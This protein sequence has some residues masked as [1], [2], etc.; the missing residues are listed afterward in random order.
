[1]LEDSTARPN[2]WLL[3]ISACSPCKFRNSQ[4]V[5]NFLIR[6]S[7]TVNDDKNSGAPA[8]G[9]YT[10][11]FILPYH[12]RHSKSLNNAHMP[13]SKKGHTFGMTIIKRDLLQMHAD[14]SVLHDIDEIPS[15][16]QYTKA[17]VIPY[18]QRHDNQNMP[19]TRKHTWGS[20][21]SVTSNGMKSFYKKTVARISQNCSMQTRVMPSKIH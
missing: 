12:Q 5:Q 15:V 20:E 21:K 14:R 8:V 17:L 4:S 13:L 11:N 2:L 16:G 6:R 3:L 18:Y 9:Q 19:S 1:M 10:S 7:M